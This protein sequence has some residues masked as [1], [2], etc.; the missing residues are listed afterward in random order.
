ME[1]GSDFGMRAECAKKKDKCSRSK[2]GK[3][4]K[5]EDLGIGKGVK[6]RVFEEVAEREREEDDAKVDEN[7]SE[8]DD[9]AVKFVVD[10]GN[11]RE[12]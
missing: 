3:E 12:L 10:V 5:D 2:S 6:G 1:V 9:G 7:L 4:V 8:S 11:S